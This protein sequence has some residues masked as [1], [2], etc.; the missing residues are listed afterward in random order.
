MSQPLHL[1]L[2]PPAPTLPTL[3]CEEVLVFDGQGLSADISLWSTLSVSQ[4]GR[5]E[6]QLAFSGCTLSPECSSSI[7][8]SKYPKDENLNSCL[9]YM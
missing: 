9:W 7:T 5:D 3:S 4:L 6:W 1:L 2:T 8:L